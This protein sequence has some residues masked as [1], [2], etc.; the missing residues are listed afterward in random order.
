M[1]LEVGRDAAVDLV[2]EGPELLG[3]MPGP[4]LADDRAGPRV[5][6]G[7]QVERAVAPVVVRPA[8]GL[9]GAHRQHRCGPLDGLDLLGWMAPSRHRGAKMAAVEG[10]QRGAIRHGGYDDRPRSGQ[11]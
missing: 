4:T 1:H 8:F 3:A 5:E 11:A 9:A 7:E 10:H 2:E 6:G